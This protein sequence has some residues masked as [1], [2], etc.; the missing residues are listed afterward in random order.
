MNVPRSG[1]AF[2]IYHPAS[3][4]Y[5][6]L[7]DLRVN[8]QQVLEPVST[9]THNPENAGY[10]L[11]SQ[12]S[13]QAPL[14]PFPASSQI[15]TTL[16]SA[17]QKLYLAANRRLGRVYFSALQDT[18]ETTWCFQPI[19]TTQPA[20]LWFGQSIWL[21][22]PQS[23]TYLTYQSNVLTVETLVQGAAS[24]WALIPTAD[25]YT[26]DPWLGLCTQTQ[27]QE[28]AI[29]P[30]HCASPTEPCVNEHLDTV[31]FSRQTCQKHCRTSSEL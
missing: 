7:P 11:I 13:E 27:G 5:L 6:G 31:Y 26:C 3:R 28:N 17:G 14:L 23:S 9:L 1:N 25:L 22:H 21:F 18:H 24:T 30:L 10:F 2:L 8:E 29:L 12:G 15:K 20:Q 16:V 19:H 4:K